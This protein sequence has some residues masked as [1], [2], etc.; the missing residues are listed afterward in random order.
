MGELILAVL[1]IPIGRALIAGAIGLAPAGCAAMG[2]GDR[3][4]APASLARPQ[5]Q[6]V[7]TLDTPVERICAD[8]AG[9]AVMDRDLPGL[10]THPDYAMFK[11]MSLKTLA[12]M[13][14]GKITPTD[15]AKVQTDLAAL[16]RSP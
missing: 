11:S 13:S 14:G 2:G 15:L 7:L 8:P 3:P 16:P 1:R 9:R 12:G 10:S 6:A 5:G 4:A